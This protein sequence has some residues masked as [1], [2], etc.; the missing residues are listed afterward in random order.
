MSIT[1]KIKNLHKKTKKDYT[2]YNFEH[3]GIIN[4]D[5]NL[6]DINHTGLGNNLFEICDVLSIAWK[7]NLNYQF[8]DLNLLFQKIPEYPTNFYRNIQKYKN[9]KNKIPIDYK[10]LQKSNLSKNNYYIFTNRRYS[11]LNFNFYR[12][13]ILKLFEIDNQSKEIINNKYKKIL[14]TYTTI[15]IHIRRTDFVVISQ[16]WNPDYIL[17][18]TYYIKA[19]DYIKNIIKSDFKFL[20]FSDDII[21]CKTFFKGNDYIFIED[22]YDYIDLWVMTLCN[23]NIISNST[24]SWWGAYLNQNKTKIIIAPKKSIFKEKKNCIQLNKTLYPKNWIILKE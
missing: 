15:G 4:K 18:N 3:G 21:W 12:N 10:I 22:N 7:F 8:P 2:N 16:I 17:K 14:N 1:C 24:F 13:R 5:I 9:S 19:I 11:Y 6:L 23:H 20:I